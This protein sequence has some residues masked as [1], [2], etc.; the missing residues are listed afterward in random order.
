MRDGRR[1]GLERRR[2]R[3][4]P[5]ETQPGFPTEEARLLEL[6][7]EAGVVHLALDTGHRYELASDSVP[8]GVPAPGEVVPAPLLAQIALAAERKTVARKVFA[9]LD[10]RLQPVARLRDKLLDRGHS[11]EAVDAVL[12]QMRERGLY[13]DRRYAEAYCRDC[14]LSRRVGRRYLVRKLREKQVTGAVATEVAAEVLDPET[15]SELAVLAASERWRKLRG[16]FDYKAV[17]KVVRFLVGR[18]FDTGLANRA[19]RG[20]RPDSDADSTAES[21]W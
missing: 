1:D 15:E 17:A 14:L 21:V 18:G 7:E 19:A 4:D 13:S 12:A 3:P 10:R 2:R 6:R 20:A 16:P 8:P 9:M 11:A 5:A